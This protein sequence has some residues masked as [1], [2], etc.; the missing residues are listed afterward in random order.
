MCSR[1]FIM[2][3]SATRKSAIDGTS[4]FYAT[5]FGTLWDLVLRFVVHEMLNME[6]RVPEKEQTPCLPLEEIYI[7]FYSRRE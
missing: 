1:W 5:C 2:R 6:P 3:N 4:N 7:Y